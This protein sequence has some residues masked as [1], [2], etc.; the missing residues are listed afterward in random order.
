MFV[1]SVI[2]DIVMTAIGAAVALVA[3]V[4]GHAELLSGT[5]VASTIYALLFAWWVGAM[6]CIV[7]SLEQQSGWRL[8][9]RIAGRWVALFAANIVVP[10]APVFV[11][12]DLDTAQR[13][14]VGNRICDPTRGK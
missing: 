6:T 4:A 10:H 11:P 5:V 8:A 3:G 9:G 14:L 2:A 12:P 1:L 13:Q 7:G